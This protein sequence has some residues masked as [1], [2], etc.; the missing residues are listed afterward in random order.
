MH[1]YAIAY[2]LSLLWVE[3]GV[4]ATPFGG[5]SE[6]DILHDCAGAFGGLDF[7]GLLGRRC[8][9]QG[10]SPRWEGC[11]GVHTTMLTTF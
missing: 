8:A 7:L 9:G 2:H 1:D 5:M 6:T 11:L 3:N 10:P 4:A